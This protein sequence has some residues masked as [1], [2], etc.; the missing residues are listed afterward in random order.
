M[1]FTYRCSGCGEITSPV[2]A[3]SIV[4]L[5]HGVPAK[6]VR[7]F[8]LKLPGETARWDPVV[9]EYVRNE[10]EFRS[11]LSQQ[12]DRESRELNMEVRLTLVDSRDKEG[13]AE[14]HGRPLT[15]WKA[16]AENTAKAKHDQAVT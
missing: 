2:A 5:E 13:I 14:L 4:C 16:E 9:G 11:I 12:M 1:N 15:T 3:D 7:S 10:A 8:G 6:R